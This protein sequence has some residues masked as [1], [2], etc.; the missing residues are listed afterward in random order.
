MRQKRLIDDACDTPSVIGFNGAVRLAVDF[1][2]GMCRDSKQMPAQ[3]S[4]ERLSRY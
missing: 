2:G 3:S 4:A 1:H